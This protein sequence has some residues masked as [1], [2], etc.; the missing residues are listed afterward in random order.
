[1]CVRDSG[2]VKF[3]CDLSARSSALTGDLA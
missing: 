1:L 2:G 3:V